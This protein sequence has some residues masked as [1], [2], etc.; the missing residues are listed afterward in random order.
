[1]SYLHCTD[2]ANHVKHNKL[3]NKSDLLEYVLSLNVDLPAN[4]ANRSGTSSTGGKRTRCEPRDES[5]SS[6]EANGTESDEGES[7]DSAASVYNVDHFVSAC[8][9]GRSY[10]LKVRWEGYDESGDTWEK[11][12]E[13]RK[14]QSAMVEEFITALQAAGQWPPTQDMSVA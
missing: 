3:A 12:S 2:G 11:V 6:E 8:K 4:D 1:M 13:L 14:Y 7:D 5:G 9:H 10:Y